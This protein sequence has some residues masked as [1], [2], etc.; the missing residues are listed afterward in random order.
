M[1]ILVRCVILFISSTVITFLAVPFLDRF[2]NF[3]CFII[4]IIA[5]AM[6]ALVYDKLCSIIEGRE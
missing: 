5:I 4:G 6:N 1:N 3:E 2:N